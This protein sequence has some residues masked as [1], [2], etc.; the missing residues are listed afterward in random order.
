MNPVFR[1]GTTIHAYSGSGPSRTRVETSMNLIESGRAYPLANVLPQTKPK[2]R[3]RGLTGMQR[4][5]ILLAMIFLL[6]L[7]W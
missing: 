3:R 2:K 1:T 7:A 6:Y 4:L 5:G